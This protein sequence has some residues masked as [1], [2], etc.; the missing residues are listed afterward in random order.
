M[1]LYLP[2]TLSR[3]YDIILG[4]AIVQITAWYQWCFKLCLINRMQSI[5]KFYFDCSHWSHVRNW[6]LHLSVIYR[7]SV[8]G[9]SNLE[10]V[11]V[12]TSASN[13]SVKELLQ[14]KR[15]K[16]EWFTNL[17]LPSSHQLVSVGK[18]AL[19]YAHGTAEVKKDTWMEVKHAVK[20]E[21]GQFKDMQMGVASPSESQITE[22]TDYLKHDKVFSD[23]IP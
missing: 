21:S 16:L 7:H 5:M 10:Q 23:I 15:F 2:L 8:A 17:T 20:R 1:W 13:A 11:W 4:K 19:H 9:Q 14:T 6:I 3:F 22:P 18:V 12:T